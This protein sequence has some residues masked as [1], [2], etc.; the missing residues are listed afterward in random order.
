MGDEQFLGG[1]PDQAAQVW[2]DPDGAAES[3]ATMEGEVQQLPVEQVQR[4]EGAPTTALGG[5][6]VQ[7]TR[8]RER[9]QPKE[10][11]TGSRRSGAHWREQHMRS[12]RGRRQSRCCCAGVGGLLNVRSEFSCVKGERER[13]SRET[14]RIV[15]EAGEE[16]FNFGRVRKESEHGRTF[17]PAYAFKDTLFDVLEMKGHLIRQ[18]PFVP[19]D[20]FWA[21]G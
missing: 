20:G 1:L 11:D 15:P 13:E 21:V 3:R 2:A 4:M 14:N 5:G 7:Y 9:A 10:V 12:W 18:S 17:L 19:N 8:G 6:G 16:I